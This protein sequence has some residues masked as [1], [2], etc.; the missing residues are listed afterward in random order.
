[1][2]IR[3]LGH[4]KRLW[5]V[6]GW[7]IRPNHKYIIM[8]SKYIPKIKSALVLGATPSFVS[9]LKSL[10]VKN[11]CVVDKSIDSFRVVNEEKRGVLDN[12]KIVI[13]DWRRYMEHSRIKWDIIM[14]DNGLFFIDTA[15]HAKYVSLISQSLVPGGIFISRQY[16]NG[17]PSECNR[18]WK[19]SI[20]TGATK[21]N[22][23]TLYLCNAFKAS[24]Y[25]KSKVSYYKLQKIAIKMVAI[26]DMKW[27]GKLFIK[28]RELIEEF[29]SDNIGQTG[30]KGELKRIC[31]LRVLKS[32]LNRLFN[33]VNIISITGPLSTFQRLI[34]ARNI[35]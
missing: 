23:A 9:L 21:D 24:N 3:S 13:D 27:K 4:K 30:F 32:I 33:D 17:S 22:M 5:S 7:P 14:N 12:C 11:I 29:I 26:L 1:M 6:M 35:K 8:L 18:D 16:V 25:G 19:R 31:K 28:Q 10:M 34:V 15:E 2:N 20:R